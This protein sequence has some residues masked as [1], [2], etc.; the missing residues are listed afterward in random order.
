MSWYV[1]SIAWWFVVGGVLAVATNRGLGWRKWWVRVAALLLS[2]TTMEQL[3]AMSPGTQLMS[4]APMWL[5]QVAS[6]ISEGCGPA[7]GLVAHF[8]CA[9]PVA[10]ARASE[11]PSQ[12][13]R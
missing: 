5:Q 3:G 13:A 11:A 1:W 7:G 10:T 12:D 9:A 2:L 4:A 8:A 6:V